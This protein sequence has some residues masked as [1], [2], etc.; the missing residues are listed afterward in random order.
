MKKPDTNKMDY[1]EEINK[2]LERNNLLRLSQE[3]TENM[4]RL[5]TTIEL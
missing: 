2:F 5:I 4:K 3:E 1:P